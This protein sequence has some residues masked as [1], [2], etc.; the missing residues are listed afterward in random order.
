MKQIFLKITLA[1][2]IALIGLLETSCSIREKELEGR[3]STS[4]CDVYAMDR[5]FWTTEYRPTYLHFITFSQGENGKLSVFTDVINPVTIYDADGAR[6]GSKITGTWEV[7]NNKL[8]LYYDENSFSLINAD[9]LSR[10]DRL[11]LEER[12]KLE[13]LDKYKTKG[14]NGLIYDITE[15]N[16][17][18]KLDIDFGNSMVTVVKE[19]ENNR[20]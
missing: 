5:I 17:R 20:N 10:N 11:I 7:K 12:L 6:I 16:N 14:S 19:E 3:W 2:C 18:K 1:C 15:K 8:F 4:V 13:F 9:T